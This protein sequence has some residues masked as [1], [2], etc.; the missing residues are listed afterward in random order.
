M[1]LGGGPKM[2]SS[3][4][5]DKRPFRCC[6]VRVTDVVFAEMPRASRRSVLHRKCRAI[7]SLGTT[8]V[9]ANLVG[10]PIAT[11]RGWL[12]HVAPFRS[13]SASSHI[14]QTRSRSREYGG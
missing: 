7:A 11:H 2:C 6:I 9:G 8:S 12:M 10:L 13:H 4:R 5:F 14:A 3:D 1:L